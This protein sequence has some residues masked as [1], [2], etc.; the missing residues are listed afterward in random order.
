M[1]IGIVY[2]TTCLVTELIYIGRTFSKYRNYFG[3]GRL[4]TD[5]IKKYGRK[6]FIRETLYTSSSVKILMAI[7]K[8]YIRKFHSDDPEIGYNKTK[9][10]EV[11]PMLN[12][13]NSPEARK[14][15]SEKKKGKG[16]GK[17]N[18]NYRNYWTKE[19]SERASKIHKGRKLTPE[20]SKEKSRRSFEFFQTEE[21]KIKAKNQSEEMT[22]RKWITNGEVNRF[23]KDTDKIPK[24]F[25]HGRLWPN[26]YKSINGSKWIT[27]GEIDKF[28][29]ENETM[30]NGF[31][32]G[33]SSTERFSNKK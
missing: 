9:G 8:L 10:G 15:I 14:K 6:N 7:E 22:G 30:P 29:K 32:H 23:I 1:R 19:Q 20:Q 13:Q 28:L 17:D 33:R 25:F 12:K 18:P 3:S 11:S 31:R 27:N 26:N 16:L 21:G 4:I 5:A 24:G 2:K